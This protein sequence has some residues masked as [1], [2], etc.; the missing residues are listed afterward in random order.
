M[1]KLNTDTSA[2][3]FPNMLYC[4]NSN[5]SHPFNPDHNK[6]CIK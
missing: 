6:F 1:G 4:A 2:D 3:K 5:C